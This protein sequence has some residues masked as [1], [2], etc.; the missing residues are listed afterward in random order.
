MRF[1]TLLVLVVLA[2]ADTV[3]DLQKED[4]RA[5]QN[6]LKKKDPSMDWF[7]ALAK[8][9]LDQKYSVLVVEAAPSELRP[10]ARYR[11]PVTAKLQVGVFIVSGATNEVQLVLDIFHQQDLG[12]NP[13][14]EHWNEHT[15][16]LH[17]Y[18]D[19]GS[20]R[21]SIKY[22]FDL[23]SRKPPVKI[24]YGILALTSSTRM[25][26]ELH[27][28]AEFIRAG[29][30]EPGWEPRY[31][32]ISIHPAGGDSLPTFKII[33]RPAPDNSVPEQAPLH[34]STGETVTVANTTPPGQP[35]Q[36]S[37]IYVA[38]KSGRKQ[39]YIVPFPTMAQYHQLLPDKQAP[40]EIENEIGP[41]ALAG[42]RL[43]FANSFYDSEGASGVGAIGT[44]DIA[45]R[46]YEMRYLP[47]IAPWSGSA[48][49]LDGN[50]LWMGLMRRPEGANY[51]TG[52]LRYNTRTGVTKLYKIPDLI[53]TI[54]RLGDTLYCGTSHG[55][56]TLRGEKMLQ[57]RFEPDVNRNRTV[58][59]VRQVP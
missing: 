7:A 28:L 16:Y 51:G 29:E 6:V 50:D 30:P 54:D 1:G 20:Y 32:T 25:N 59:V 46:R 17:F 39:F 9:L 31:A 53:Y 38:S 57:L 3:P 4:L 43:W 22:V 58:M 5:I 37:G 15:V 10:G 48:M 26:G 49:L 11:S 14:I 27:N 42:A 8:K 45:A 55:L 47:E 56:Y 21:G 12:S 23:S 52:L 34:L 41:Y 36:P 18:E 35:Q 24:P 19:Y 2:S 13:V 40:G 44:F 33:E